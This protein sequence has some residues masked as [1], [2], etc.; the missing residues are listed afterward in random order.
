[1]PR[2]AE[3]K[4]ADDALREA[5]WGAIKAM[6]LSD[7]KTADQSGVLTKFMVV[8]VQVD[9]DDEGDSR[10]TTTILYSDGHVL[11]F[12]AEGMLAQANRIFAAGT[13]TRNAGYEE[14]E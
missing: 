5:V 11:G 13:F 9:F 4:A 10:D 2:T 3:Q 1:M 12:E 7:G 8:A 14:T 6:V